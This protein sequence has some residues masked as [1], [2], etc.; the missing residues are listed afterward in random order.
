MGTAP[1]ERPFAA[2]FRSLTEET[3][4]PELKV[5][6]ALPGWLRG[7]LLRNGP[8]LYEAGDRSLR[9]WFDGQAMVHRF[10]FDGARGRVGYANRFLDTPSHRAVAQGRISYPEFATDP[11]RS[12]FARVFTRF[13]RE[14]TTNTCVS[15]TRFG[16]RFVA[17]TE[18]PLPVE[19][20]PATLETLGVV[21]YED[22]LNGQV[23]TAHPH[24]DPDTGDLVNYVTRFGA[25]SEYRVYRQKMDGGTAR[26]LIGVQRARHPSYMHSFAVTRRYA[27]LTEF[28][29]V[30]TPLS[31][32]LSG[33]PFIE[34]Y[35]WEP[36]RGTR[37][38]VMDLRDGRLRGVYE[39]PACFA[40]H[41]IN[42]FD[43]GD[44]VVLDLCA[45]ED[46]SVIDTLYLDRARTCGELPL[47]RP[48]RYRVGL[49][50]GKVD[51]ERLTPE[52]MELPRIAYETRNGS[53]Y[54]YAYGVGAR[55][56]RRDDFLDQLVKLDVTTGETHTWYEQGSYPGE[57]VLVR[58]PDAPDAP[59]GAEDDG[60]VLSVVLDPTA[61]ASYLLVLDARTLTERAR[62][63]VPH[64]VPF[65]F[66]GIHTTDA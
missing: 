32:M 42:A 63:R 3:D 6:G 25:T 19:F 7:S 62:A 34:N 55:D 10:T 13:T 50:T 49:S 40:F 56:G 36:A 29:L 48:T 65:G 61:R 30:V 38:T 2:G 12:I 5:E 23:T 26:E 54:R 53:S 60:V 37:I 46:A 52:A 44:D 64:M 14:P 43:D 4:L 24:Q 59:E 51:V 35:R 9:H 45:Y 1:D 58:A 16:E 41:H 11:C 39:G 15:L 27:V 20:D 18:T 17:L 31:I 57:P 8:A 21:G 47:S 66:H 28:P 33:R 22:A